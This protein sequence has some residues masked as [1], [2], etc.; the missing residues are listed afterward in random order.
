MENVS[1]S[2]DISNDLLFEHQRCLFAASGNVMQ[3]TD[4]LRRRA[5]SLCVCSQL[6]SNDMSAS[7]AGDSEH[8][9]VLL[10]Y[11]VTLDGQGEAGHSPSHYLFV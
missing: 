4:Q 5:T 2:C 10:Q 6:C 8:R 3:R 1:A 11:V 9:R 7:L